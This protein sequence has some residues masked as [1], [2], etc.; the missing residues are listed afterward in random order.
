M[1]LVKRDRTSQGLTSLILLA[2]FIL[3][4]SSCSK[5]APDIREQPNS[6]DSQLAAIKEKAQSVASGIGSNASNPE[7]QIVIPPPQ[8]QEQQSN[9]IST[10]NIFSPNYR[11][12]CIVE[13]YKVLNK[14]C[15]MKTF[16]VQQSELTSWY[17]PYYIVLLAL[18]VIAFVLWMGRN[19]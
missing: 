14:Y 4:I 18:A 16:W 15:G 8:Q 7:E 6:F 9:I 3:F 11:A 2:L 12:S 1:T 5:A 10:S 19:K 17:I 13:K